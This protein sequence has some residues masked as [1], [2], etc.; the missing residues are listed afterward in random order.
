MYDETVSNFG[1]NTRMNLRHY[2]KE[3]RARGVDRIQHN[4]LCFLYERSSG[5]GLLLSTSQLN[6]SRF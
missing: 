6:L 4:A 3:L 5:R 2:T 1:F